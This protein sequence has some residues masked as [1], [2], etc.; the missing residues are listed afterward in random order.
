MTRAAEDEAPDVRHPRETFDLFGH[1]E[2]ERTVLD[3]YRSGR[4]PHAWLIGCPPG[5][6]K[7]TLAYRIAR[8]VLAHPDPRAVAD[9]QSLAVDP[10]HPTARRIAAQAHPDL[11]VLRRTEGESGALRAVITVGDVRRTI[12]FFGS[13]AG[14]G[15][16]R[17][18]IVDTADEL[19]YPQAANALLK[20]IE[21]PPAHSLFLLLSDAPGRLLAT[22]RSRCRRISLRPLGREDV[23]RAA[24]AATGRPPDDPDLLAAAD[25]AEGSVGRAVGLLDGQKLALLQQINALL[26]RLPAVDPRALHALG[27]NLAA[28]DAG[29]LA[30]FVEAVQDWLSARLRASDGSLHRLAQVAEVW[31]KV[32][33]AARDVEIYNLERKPLVFS[34]FGLLADTARR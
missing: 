11:L 7:A 31:E 13:T 18:C 33:A 5:V 12:G 22:I 27:E 10:G 21:E 26:A 2:A 23:I 25:A 17:V 14:E 1:A 28:G 24:A 19:Q 34:V 29:A 16:W 32:A 6:G 8:F 3:A 20:I 15:G 30:T 4:M 9:A